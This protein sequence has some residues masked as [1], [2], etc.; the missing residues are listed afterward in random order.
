[1]ELTGER[2][3]R[4]PRSRLYDALHDPR[5]LRQAIP[6]CEAVE[7]RADG[8]YEM[9]LAVRI[10]PVRA[11]VFGTVTVYGRERPQGYSLRAEA[12]GGLA[13]NATGDAHVALAT[14]DE[15]TTNLAYHIMADLSGQ[16]ARLDPADVESAARALIAEFFERLER[17]LDA[18]HTIATSPPTTDATGAPIVAARRSVRDE[19]LADEDAWSAASYGAAEDPLPP[20]PGAATDRP[21][22]ANAPHVVLLSPPSDPGRSAPQAAAA[23]AAD[24]APLRP[25]A[26]ARREARPPQDERPPARPGRRRRQ[27]VPRPESDGTMTPWRWFLVVLGLAAIVALLTGSL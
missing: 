24:A 13:G 10:G 21:R 16:F 3:V 17:S 7:R 11:N 15:R 25:A 2:V 14:I 23:D 1:V 12:T 18:A 20:P 4:A 6:R 9:A 5:L 22:P 27:R 26:N 19:A 8:R